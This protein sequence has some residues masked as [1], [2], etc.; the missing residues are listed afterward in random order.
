MFSQTGVMEEASHGQDG[1][2]IHGKQ[3]HLN[4]STGVQ[5]GS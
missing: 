2:Y 4:G 5:A 1:P 3:G